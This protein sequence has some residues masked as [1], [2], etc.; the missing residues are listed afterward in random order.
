MRTDSGPRLFDCGVSAELSPHN[1]EGIDAVIDSDRR[2]V[3]TIARVGGGSALLVSLPLVAV[4]RSLPFPVM[5]TLLGG[6]VAVLWP[7]LWPALVVAALLLAGGA[8]LL[9]IGGTGLLFVV[10]TLLVVGA[11]LGTAFQHEAAVGKPAS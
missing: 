4:A 8:V 1:Q 7:T 10:P 3:L 9:L 5:F 2:G 11:A 6:L